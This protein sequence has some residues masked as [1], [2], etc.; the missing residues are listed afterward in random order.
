MLWNK[1]PTVGSYI[2][3]HQ[4]HSDAAKDETHCSAC[5]DGFSSRSCLDGDS[6]LVL[7]GIQDYASDYVQAGNERT[8]ELGDSVFEH[9][10][11]LSTCMNKL[12]SFSS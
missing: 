9:P 12:S 6:F 7:Q 4:Q 1:L 2:I 5:H 11:K 3:H 10:E 8:H